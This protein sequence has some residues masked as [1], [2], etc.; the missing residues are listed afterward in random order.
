MVAGGTIT[1][2]GLNRTLS[3]LQPYTQY[4]VFVKAINSTGFADSSVIN[5]RTNQV[6]TGISF[7]VT[8][9][10]II[11]VSE[12]TV[13]KNSQMKT[14]TLVRNTPIK[15]CTANPLPS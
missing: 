9:I 14:T 10:V 13:C 15:F 2:V 5:V 7:S 3:P 1:D 4:H 6:R 8:R 11:G 12:F